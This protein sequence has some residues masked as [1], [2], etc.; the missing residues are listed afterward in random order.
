MPDFGEMIGKAKDKLSQHS[1]KV[2]EGMEKGKDFINEKTDGKYSDQLDKGQE[3]LGDY[4]GDDS[5]S[6]DDRQN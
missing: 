2:D 4:L 1:D 5:G 3:K 6:G